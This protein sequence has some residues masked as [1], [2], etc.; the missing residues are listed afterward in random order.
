MIIIIEIN[1]AHK[2]IRKG[3]CP[4]RQSQFKITQFKITDMAAILTRDTIDHHDHCYDAVIGE[5]QFVQLEIIVFPKSFKCISTQ[6]HLS[7]Q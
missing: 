1:N 7:R 6:Y 4:R 5:S 3:R 2:A